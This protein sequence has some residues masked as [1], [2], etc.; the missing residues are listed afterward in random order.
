M[1]FLKNRWTLGVSAA[2][3]AATALYYAGSGN[4]IKEAQ[5]Q[6]EAQRQSELEAAKKTYV[7]S[8]KMMNKLPRAPSAVEIQHFEGAFQTVKNFQALTG[9]TAPLQNL[10][11]AHDTQHSLAEKLHMHMYYAYLDPTNPNH[12][13]L[14]G[15]EP[16]HA[17]LVMDMVEALRK[18]HR[19]FPQSPSQKPDDKEFVM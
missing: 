19:D 18:P 12:Y 9:I 8:F 10:D 13:I 5:K 17:G 4:N 1:S 11:N 3:I 16:R 6:F 15:V 14:I 7:S 2:A